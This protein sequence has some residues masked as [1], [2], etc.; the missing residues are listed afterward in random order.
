MNTSTGKVYISRYL[1]EKDN[2]LHK[3]GLAQLFDRLAGRTAMI[4]NHRAAQDRVKAILDIA[5]LAMSGREALECSSGMSHAVVLNSSFDPDYANRRGSVVT[6]SPHAPD[7]YAANLVVHELKHG[8]QEDSVG[9]A[10]GSLEF[11]ND[12]A[13]GFADTAYPM[14]IGE[15]DAFTSQTIHAYELDQEGIPGPWAM[16]RFAR[17]YRPLATTLAAQLDHRHGLHSSQMRQAL[18]KAWM[19]S[20]HRLSYEIEYLHDIVTKPWFRGKLNRPGLTHSN[21]DLQH[22]ADNDQGY[23]PLTD[24]DLT[25]RSFVGVLG[26]AQSFLDIA[27]S[28]NSAWR[29]VNLFHAFGEAAETLDLA[30]DHFE[31]HDRWKDLP[32]FYGAPSLTEGG[33]LEHFGKILDVIAQLSDHLQSVPDSAKRIRT[34]FHRV[35]TLA[36]R[37]PIF[38]EAVGDVIKEKRNMFKRL[39]AATPT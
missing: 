35:E 21:E 20:P 33:R 28:L 29:A 25:D 22:I 24:L 27:Q 6:V 15:A 26:E 5:G 19:R 12:N 37:H 1:E 8:Q 13:V 2:H 17:H 36:K 38:K 3:G 11:F 14:L 7:D 18:F 4:R 23:S 31:G 10:F 9:N 30:E 16:Q 39:P 32:P 34:L